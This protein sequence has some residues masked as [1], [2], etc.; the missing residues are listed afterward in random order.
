MA[1]KR[2]AQ[3]TVT[4]PPF[5]WDT[6]ATPLGGTRTRLARAD[7][8]RAEIEVGTGVDGD[9]E[10]VSQRAR[11]WRTKPAPMM[12]NLTPAARAAVLVYIEAVEIVGGS[13]G[14]SDAGGSGTGSSSPTA[15]PSVRALAE[16]ERLR[17]MHA[18][19]EGGELVVPHR[20][21]RQ[22]RR[23]DGLARTPFRQLLEWMAI[24]GLGRNDIL[25]RA[26]ASIG[27][28]LAQSE[29]VVSIAAVGERLAISCGYISAPHSKSEFG[30]RSNV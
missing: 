29:L 18:A 22:Q 3:G 26:G 23:G 15:G 4:L 30:Q 16:A 1:R 21:A 7:V 10:I 28:E 24:D 25:K 2:K 8:E 20:E 17:M 27:N 19:L 5:A 14:G 11:V 9:G 6:H 13:I 12:A